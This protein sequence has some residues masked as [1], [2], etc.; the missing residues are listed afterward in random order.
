MLTTMVN[1]LLLIEVF[2]MFSFW[3]RMKD[4]NGNER[5]IQKYMD[6][7]TA[8]FKMKVLQCQNKD[9]EYW[10]EMRA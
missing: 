9:N 2:M 1:G 7:K 10:I 5:T 8:L 6:Y 3:V 4:K